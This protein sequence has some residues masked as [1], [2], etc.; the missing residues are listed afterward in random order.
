MIAPAPTTQDPVVRT[1]LEAMARSGGPASPDETV[2]EYDWDSPCSFGSTEAVSL[3]E[4]VEALGAGMSQALR[5][6]VQGQVALAGAGFRE[7]YAAQLAAAQ[8]QGGYGVELTDERDRTIGT[9][10]LTCAGAR[11][12]MAGLLGGSPAPEAAGATELTAVEAGVLLE[13][14]DLVAQAF[15][16]AVGKRGGGGLKS[17]GSLASPPRIPTDEPVREYG[18]MAFKMDLSRPE[19]DLVI[20]IQ[21]G[22]LLAAC[23]G[24]KP[25][26][27]RPPEETRKWMRQYAEVGVVGAPVQLPATSV[28]VRDLIDLQEGDVLVLG[29]RTCDPASLVIDGKPLFEGLP[30]DCEGHYGLRIL[31]RVA[32]PKAGKDASDKKG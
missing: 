22:I 28:P 1:L 27:T 6:L 17:R 21:G 18:R 16:Q 13:A 31:G 10:E 26:A 12:L 2:A 15:V 19:A 24:G 25:V 5:S 3:G 14:V 9:I 4:F 30:V 23:G 29:S 32:A 7:M 11:H 8:G 20:T